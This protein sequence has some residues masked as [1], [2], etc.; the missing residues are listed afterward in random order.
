[1]EV[2][3]AAWPPH[4]VPM[5]ER[6]PPI[7]RPTWTMSGVLRER[8]M[9]VSSRCRAASAPP[10]GFLLPTQKFGPNSVAVT[11]STWQSWGLY[12]CYEVYAVLTWMLSCT[13]RNSH[14]HRRTPVWHREQPA[15]VSA[16]CWAGIDIPIDHWPKFRRRPPLCQAG[17]TWLIL[18][19]WRVPGDN[20]FKGRFPNPV[21]YVKFEIQRLSRDPQI[22]PEAV[23]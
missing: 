18:V 21:R 5:I 22:R 15:Q 12:G 16:G 20:E 3:R 6:P 19:F 23:G 7:T 4:G 14:A 9:Q 17:F 13:F 8:S 11:R 10:T 2:G 1:M